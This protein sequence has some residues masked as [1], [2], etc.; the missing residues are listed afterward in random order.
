MQVGGIHL[1]E[2]N[3]NEINFSIPQA[4]ETISVKVS[5][6]LTRACMH[7]KQQ[8]SF[9]DYLKLLTRQQDQLINYVNVLCSS[10]HLKVIHT[11][12]SI[13]FPVNIISTAFSF[14][15]KMC[16]VICYS[17]ITAFMETSKVTESKSSTH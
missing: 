3:N 12:C 11:Q 13:V 15:S 9:I 8:I 14:A 4:A 10:T 1:C 5:C 2:E 16:L 7:K 17:D 6:L